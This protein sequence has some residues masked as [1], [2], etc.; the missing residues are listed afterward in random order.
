MS[1]S[2]RLSSLRDLRAALRMESVLKNA[3]SDH[4]TDIAARAIA[5]TMRWCLEVMTK[6]R[7]MKSLPLCVLLLLVSVE[8]RAEPSDASP[9]EASW[10]AGEWEV[11]YAPSPGFEELVSEPISVVRIEHL[12]GARIAR[13]LLG[14][15]EAPQARTEFTVKAW[16]GN[17]PWWPDEGFGLV[18]RK[19]SP[20]TFDLAT[21]GPDGRADWG[22]ALRHKRISGAFEHLKFL[23]K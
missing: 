16:A 23:G 9:A 20:D 8:A 22:R 6:N 1:R 17:L 18:A 15:G 4:P 5:P 11:R 14:R 2:A 13:H 7:P 3:S 21:L 10:F 19:V 12:G